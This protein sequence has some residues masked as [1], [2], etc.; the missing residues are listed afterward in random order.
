MTE[1]QRYYEELDEEV[2]VIIEEILKL[3]QD[4]KRLLGTATQEFKNKLLV[5]I[6]KN[7]K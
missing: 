2:K 7:I 1:I 5:T 4:S 3:E 6:K